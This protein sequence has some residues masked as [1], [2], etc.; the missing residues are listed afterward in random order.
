MYVYCTF[1]CVTQKSACNEFF[2]FLN[3]NHQKAI[4]DK[5]ENKTTSVD[6]HSMYVLVFACVCVCILTRKC[7]SFLIFSQN[8][9]CKCV[10]QDYQNFVDR[11]ALLAANCRKF[12]V[13]HH[14]ITN[15]PGDLKSHSDDA[16]HGW[17]ID[18]VVWRFAASVGG[19]LWLLFHFVLHRT[20]CV[21]L[22]SFFQCIWNSL[23]RGS[24]ASV[25]INLLL[26]CWRSSAAASSPFSAKFPDLEWKCNRTVALFQSR[27]YFFRQLP[28]CWGV[29]AP[30]FV[31][32]F[33]GMFIFVS[34]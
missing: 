22:P 24:F 18:V 5:D 1:I 16:N 15:G 17:W 6:I 2:S 14:Q 23:C 34:Y 33:I 29:R 7:F 31:C 9:E 8:G 30:V 32:A 21:I 27:S 11:R 12:F 4:F 26:L 13:C 3:K 20:S 28:G 19:C 25:W 10:Q